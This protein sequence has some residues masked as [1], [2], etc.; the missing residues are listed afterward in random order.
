MI[1]PGLLLKIKD[2]INHDPTK[3]GWLEMG[4]I[5]DAPQSA[6]DAFEEYKRMMQWAKDNNLEI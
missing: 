4:L 6:I 5:P 2:Y 1:K 3:K